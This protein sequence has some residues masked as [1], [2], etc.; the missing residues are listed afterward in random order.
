MHTSVVG[1][2][3]QACLD[4]TLFD[5]QCSA[6][7]QTANTAAMLEAFERIWSDGRLDDD[8]AP[9][10]CYLR[11][12]TLLEHRLNEEQGL[13]LHSARDGVERTGRVIQDLRGRIQEIRRATREVALQ[14]PSKAHMQMN[15]NAKR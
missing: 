4:D 13:L 3:P 15:G 9:D 5:A 12:H 14:A 2:R 6:D 10:L 1:P 11:R 8:D 7:A